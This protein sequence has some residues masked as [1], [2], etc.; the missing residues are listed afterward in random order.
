MELLFYFFISFIQPIFLPTP[1]AIAIVA[2]SKKFGS[3]TAF[4]VGYLGIILGALTIYFIAYFGFSKVLKLFIN[5]KQLEK[6][7]N[8]NAA[9]NKLLLFGLFLFPVLPD[10][11]ICVSSGMI[12][13]NFK[14]FLSVL[15]ISKFIT[16]I[17]YAYFFEI[18]NSIDRIYFILALVSVFIIYLFFRRKL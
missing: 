16:T 11:I 15:L 4:T 1:E 8:S 3:F 6:F 9:S 17:T 10:D 2:A 7:K 14:T 13:L 5:D 18:Y 12:R